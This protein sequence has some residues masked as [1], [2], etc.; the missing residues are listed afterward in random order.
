MLKIINTIITKHNEFE[1][2]LKKSKKLIQIVNF[3]DKKKEQKK[4]NLYEFHK[5]L[6]QSSLKKQITAVCYVNKY[7]I[8]LLNLF[9][10]VGLIQAYYHIAPI[11]FKN[12]LRFGYKQTFIKKIVI[13]FFIQKQN[14]GRL[15]LPKLLIISKPSRQIFITYKKLL[16][17]NHHHPATTFF[18][19]NTTHGLITH[20][21]A[22][23]KKIGGNLICIVK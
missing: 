14:S 18:F 22:L 20:L 4:I 11:F 6:I 13:I 17:L 3:V 12:F 5:S 9:K 21:E 1:K 15:Y 8:N 23:Q 19:L 7:L 16:E 2:I 10:K